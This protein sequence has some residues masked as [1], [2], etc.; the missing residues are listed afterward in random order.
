MNKYEDKNRENQQLYLP[1]LLSNLSNKPVEVSYSG[2]AMSSDGGAL[3]LREVEKQTGLIEKLNQCINDQRDDRYVKHRIK[4]L[5]S[6]RIYQI[7]CGYED[8][9]DCDALRGDS[10]FKI[11]A[12]KMPESDPDLASQP[13]MSRFENA[14][15]QRE[16]YQ[17]AKVF[18][19]YFMASYSQA[20]KV[21]ILDCDDTNNN[22]YGAQ[23]LSLFNFYY[24][25]YC[26]MPLHIYE[27][28]SGKLIATI[29]KPGRRSKNTNVFAIL[30]RIIAYL[31]QSWK[32]TIIIVRGDA[33]FCSSELMDWSSNQPNVHF[34]TGLTG[35]ARLKELAKVTIQSAEETFQISKRKVKRYHSFQYQAAGWQHPQRVIVKVEVSHKGTNVRYI[36]TDMQ[37]FRASHVYEKA[38]CHR[39]AMELRIKDHKLYLKSD[40]SSCSSFQANQFRLFLHSAAY[41][42][43]HSLQKGAFNASEFC[44]ST[45]KTI[46]LKILKTAAW[47]KEMKTKI[48][49]ELPQSFAEIIT[50]KEAF[51]YFSYYR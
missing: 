8:G 46:Q 22:T 14:T 27:G 21:I 17:M 5:L 30:R 50:Q 44:G 31:R 24:D 18:V 9:N 42:L 10:I 12:D 28:F 7:A 26:Y 45:M 34:V 13:T 35:N 3:L 1:F 43:I 49:I 36:V 20:P 32:D 41:A 48:K 51:E 4:E 2:R 6:Q 39:G 23:Q 25:E 47:V 38:F 33:H 29:L 19:D 37:E 15:S 16:L 40:R 11:C